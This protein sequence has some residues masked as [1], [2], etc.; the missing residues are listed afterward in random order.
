MKNHREYLRIT[1]FPNW[2]VFIEELSKHDYD[3][4]MKPIQKKRSEGH[5]EYYCVCCKVPIRVYNI[6]RFKVRQV[7][8]C[9]ICYL[10]YYEWLK[11]N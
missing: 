10:A 6:E 3:I 9:Q 2:H 1:K 8:I 11:K 7:P 5:R 4:L